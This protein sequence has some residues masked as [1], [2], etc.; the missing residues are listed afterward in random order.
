MAGNFALVVFLGLILQRGTFSYFDAIFWATVCALL[1]IRYA[2]LKWLRGLGADAQPATMKDWGKYAR[3]LILI[4][5]GAWVV[6]HALLMLF[7]R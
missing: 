6:V 1:F 5:G 2:D 3:L 4:A 7:R